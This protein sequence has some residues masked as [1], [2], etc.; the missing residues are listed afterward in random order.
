[1]KKKITTYGVN[2]LMECVMSI[3]VGKTHMRV[4]FTGGVL[5]SYGNTPATFTTKDPLMQSII[6]HSP[7]FK[8][9]RITIVGLPIE[10][11]EDVE[12]YVHNVPKVETKDKSSKPSSKTA[13]TA[14]AAT[15]EG[16]DEDESGTSVDGGTTNGDAGT[17]GERTPDGKLIVK[18]TS[19]DDAKSYLNEK[20]GIAVRELRSRAKILDAA[21]ANGVSFE[22]I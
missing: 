13:D 1:M 4:E 9:G 6:E 7:Q 20:C 21:D 14:A 10:T 22:G 12:N 15:K 16:S 3:P 8:S 2:G 19:L 11:D 5:T 17:D 18:V